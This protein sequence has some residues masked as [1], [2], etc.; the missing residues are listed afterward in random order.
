MV[1]HE[2]LIQCARHLD[3]AFT[4]LDRASD[5]VQV[6]PSWPQLVTKQGLLVEA[7]RAVDAAKA[8]LEH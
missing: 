1:D 5:A 6:M 8:A 3:R 2:M 7:R 4:L